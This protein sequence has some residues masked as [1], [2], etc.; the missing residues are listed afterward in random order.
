MK[1]IPDSTYAPVGGSDGAISAED[2]PYFEDPNAP[3]F[4]GEGYQD[5][6]P[7]AYTAPLPEDAPVIDGPPPEGAVMEG[8]VEGAGGDLVE[9]LLD[10]VLGN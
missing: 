2:V 7:D 5:P 3:I 1:N 4:D 9:Q 6:L 8:P 10:D